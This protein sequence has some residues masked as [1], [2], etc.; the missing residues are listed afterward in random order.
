[1]T[2]SETKLESVGDKHLLFQVIMSW[3]FRLLLLVAGKLSFPIIGLVDLK[4]SFIVAS[5]K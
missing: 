3:K 1:M 2:N 5:C 4:V